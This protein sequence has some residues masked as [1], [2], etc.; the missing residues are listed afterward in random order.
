MLL[1]LTLLTLFRPLT[2]LVNDAHDVHQL[3]R[4]WTNNWT[5]GQNRPQLDIYWTK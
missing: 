3:D 2:E 1:M 4:N 5:T